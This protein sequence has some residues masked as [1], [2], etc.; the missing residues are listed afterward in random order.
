MTEAW[1]RVRQGR[2]P[3]LPHSLLSLGAP[4]LTP[5]PPCRIPAQRQ[6]VILQES[7]ISSTL[8]CE[9]SGVWAF[10]LAWFSS[11]TRLGSRTLNKLCPQFLFLINLGL[12]DSQLAGQVS[13]DLFFWGCQLPR[14]AGLGR[15]GENWARTLALFPVPSQGG[16]GSARC[17]FIPWVAGGLPWGLQS[18]A[19]PRATTS[20]EAYWTVT[21][22]SKGA[23]LGGGDGTHL[24]PTG[25]GG[26]GV[27]PCDLTRCFLP[28]WEFCFTPKDLRGF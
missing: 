23:F 8:A 24:P 19:S 10:P 16:R 2:D 25:Q 3:V 7:C 22:L 13:W 4:S 18:V 12:L 17:V 5:P 26:G 27:P 11:P 20:S 15:V 28:A 9:G 1:G 14:N 21:Q 6:T